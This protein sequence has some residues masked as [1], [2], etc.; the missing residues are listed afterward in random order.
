MKPVPV[1]ADDPVTACKIPARVTAS[2]MVSSVDKDHNSFIMFPTQTISSSAERETLPM[3]AVLEKG[4]KWPNPTARLP[5]P[6]AFVAFT[7]KLAHFEDNTG[8]IKADLQSRAVISL[9]SIT[10]LRANYGPT[11][12]PLAPSTSRLDDADTVTL[13]SRVLKFSHSSSSSK[14]DVQPSGIGTCKKSASQETQG[15]SD[16]ET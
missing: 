1:L 3:R 6:H 2:G 11:T 13:K 16:D 7:G 5:S 4:P 15:Q 12:T 8:K 14:I 9:D 10:Y